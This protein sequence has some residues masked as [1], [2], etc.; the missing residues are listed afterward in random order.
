VVNPDTGQV[1]AGT[2]NGTTS[3]DVTGTVTEVAAYR[4]TDLRSALAPVV[5][6]EIVALLAL[7]P[8]VYFLWIRRRKV[9]S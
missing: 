2:G 1:N 6:I 4:A 3:A 9:G 8:A 7:P 5:A